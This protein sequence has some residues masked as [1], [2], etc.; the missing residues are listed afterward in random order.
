MARYSGGGGQLQAL[1]PDRGVMAA[2]IVLTAVCIIINFGG[3]A[4][5]P[6]LRHLVL[7]PR[8]AI[9]WEP[10]QLVTNAFL[11]PSFI[12]LILTF[13]MLIF[14]GNPIEQ[15]MGAGGFWKIFLGGIIGGSLLAALVGRVIAPETALAGAQPAMTALLVA[16]G[17]LW[18]GQQVRAYG[19]AQMSATTMTWIF[20]GINVLVCMKAIS[21]DWHQG[22]MSLCAVV[23]AAF[24]GWLLTRRG[25]VNLGASFDKMRMWRL[26][27][28]YKVLTGG[29]DSRDDKRF[30][31]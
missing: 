3:A 24:A 23:G 2:M 1:K 26:K 4:V 29:R 14:F 6:A 28:R 16:F 21:V 20:V 13:V 11:E 7:T 5:A 19:V 22:V 31:N 15:R 17:A 25:G 18:R 27:R 10:W 9:G 8:T 30:L 12:D